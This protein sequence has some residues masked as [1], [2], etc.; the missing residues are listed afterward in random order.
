MIDDDGQIVIREFPPH[1]IVYPIA[2]GWGAWAGVPGT[3][4][5][6]LNCAGTTG[7]ETGRRPPRRDRPRADRRRARGAGADPE[8][9][10]RVHVAEDGWSAEWPA[11]GIDLGA[12]RL[13]RW[14][15]EQA[16]ETMPAEA[17]RAWMEGRSL[18]LDRA[19]DAL[20]LSRR[21]VACHL[22]GGLPVPRTVMRRP[23]AMTSGGRH[24]EDMGT[25]AGDGPRRVLAPGGFG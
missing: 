5:A 7:R 20:G 23:K 3:C 15:D 2:P 8:A 19:A 9:F 16:G 11:V 13:R 4:Q 24:D 6:P 21:T 14:A 17:F 12:A 22:R 18:T 1:R 10:H 25:I